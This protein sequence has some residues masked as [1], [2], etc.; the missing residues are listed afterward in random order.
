MSISFLPCHPILFCQ[1]KKFCQ[2]GAKAPRPPGP[3][4]ERLWEGIETLCN[5][6][7]SG[8]LDESWSYF[9]EVL[10]YDASSGD[11]VKTGDLQTPRGYHGVST[12]NWNDIAEFCD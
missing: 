10:R 5:S 6:A 3:P 7:Y 11:W 4:Q 12:V 9:S 8:G 1:A 2:G